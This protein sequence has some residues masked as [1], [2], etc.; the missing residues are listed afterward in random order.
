MA[1]KLSNNINKVKSK[2]IMS[3]LNTISQNILIQKIPMNKWISLVNYTKK[4]TSL[5]ARNEAVKRNNENSKLNRCM[6]N[7]D[8]D[9]NTYNK[10]SEEFNRFEIEKYKIKTELYKFKNEF[11]NKR[12]LKY[13]A[14]QNTS[15]R[16]MKKLKID[17]DTVE[18][19][20]DIRKA[21][22]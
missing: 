10:L 22:T 9:N 15:N 14:Q 20:N 8:L 6:N 5:W 3:K 1:K 2:L 7:L 19:D 16:T 18:D 11:E 17:N 12:L 13:K 4:I 21:L